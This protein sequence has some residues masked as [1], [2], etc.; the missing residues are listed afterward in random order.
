MDVGVL[1]AL[2]EHPQM[3]AQGAANLSCIL[4]LSVPVEH[5]R[6]GGCRVL[7]EPVARHQ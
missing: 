3:L 4:M 6:D 2:D 7:V 1:R 5:R